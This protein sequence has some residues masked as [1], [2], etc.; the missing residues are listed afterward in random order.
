MLFK[1]PVTTLLGV[2]TLGLERDSNIKKWCFYS[3]IVAIN[4]F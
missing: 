1:A 3:Q 2:M 4:Q